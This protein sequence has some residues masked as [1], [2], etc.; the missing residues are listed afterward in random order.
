MRKYLVILFSVFLGF[1]QAQSQKQ[2][3]QQGNEA[4]TQQQYVVALKQYHAVADSGWQSVELFY[5]MGNSYF[6]LGKTGMSILYFEKALKLNP[7]DQDV[8]NNLKIAESNRIDFF[9]EVPV[10]VLKRI[11][12]SIL[13]VFSSRLWAV[14]GIVFVFVG[15]ILLVLFL[16]KKNKSMLF[17]TSYM[18]SGIVGLVLLFIGYQKHLL[19]KNNNY[20]VL[21]IPN[22]YVKSEPQGQDLYILHEGTKFLV[23]E[24]FQEWTK[25]RLSNGKSG[26]ALS[27][28]IEEI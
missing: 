14:L 10:P 26:W 1:L 6:R 27:E 20:G 8:L 11:W 17:F 19:D 13:N 3:F 5:N 21:V 9:D 25:L 28:G 16:S 24:S 22:T 4:Y 7:K 18:F 15:A 23:E 2:I 12:R